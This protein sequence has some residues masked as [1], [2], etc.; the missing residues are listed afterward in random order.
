ME[1]RRRGRTSPCLWPLHHSHPE[2]RTSRSR[3]RTYR[4]PREH[5]HGS[6]ATSLSGL[7]SRPRY[8]SSVPRHLR[9]TLRSRGKFCG[10]CHVNWER[11]S[12]WH[13]QHSPSYCGHHSNRY[14]RWHRRTTSRTGRYHT[15]QARHTDG[16]THPS[17]THQYRSERCCDPTET[18]RSRTSFLSPLPQRQS[19]AGC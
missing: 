15:R 4:Y 5:S 1:P 3:Y 16:G 19:H 2:A 8:L 13:G 14:R 18:H 7:P 6:R 9:P 17:H 10:Y 11:R 12:M